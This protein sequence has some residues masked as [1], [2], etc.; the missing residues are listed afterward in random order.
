MPLA[1]ARWGQDSTIDCRINRIRFR[2]KSC[3][4]NP[5]SRFSRHRRI[6]SRFRRCSSRNLSPA[7]SACGKNAWIRKRHGADRRKWHGVSGRNRHDDSNSGKN[8]T[9]TLC[10]KKLV[11]RCNVKGQYRKFD[12]DQVA[13]VR[14][15][16]KGVTAM[17][18]PSQEEQLSVL[19]N[20]AATNTPQLWDTMRPKS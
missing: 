7:R 13:D 11:K 5:I 3:N 19:N 1:L 9:A 16:Q 17:Q 18:F 12:P 6:R 20:D 14:L 2:C 8:K 4:R 10:L 15:A